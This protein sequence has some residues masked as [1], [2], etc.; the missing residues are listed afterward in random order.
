MDK[1]VKRLDDLGLKGKQF[2]E[3]L[4]ETNTIMA[5]SFPLQ[6]LL[7]E[8]YGDSDIDLYCHM[9]LYD[10][11]PPF[12]QWLYNNFKLKHHPSCINWASYNFIPGL[13]K[14][15]SYSS[16][17]ITIQIMIVNDNISPCQFV[18]TWFDLSFCEVIFDGKFLKYEDRVLNKLGSIN[19][20]YLN[21]E[22][23]TWNYIYY[24][25][26]LKYEKRGFTINNKDDYNKGREIAH[27]HNKDGYNLQPFNNKEKEISHYHDKRMLKIKNNNNVILECLTYRLLSLDNK[28]PILPYEIRQYI[29][30]LS[31]IKLNERLIHHKQLRYH[32][33]PYMNI[34]KC[35]QE[36]IMILSECKCEFLRQKIRDKIS[37]PLD[38][39]LS[40][41]Y[42]KHLDYDQPSVR[43]NLEKV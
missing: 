17:N 25:R 6:C 20:K 14:Y 31:K 9:P 42:N 23:Q 22:Y 3:K 34:V 11:Y 16:Q 35:F 33:C 15:Y 13:I 8:N 10:I 39:F 37:S 41:I 7:G 30:Y 36:N 38:N 29:I 12:G 24:D 28:T 4:Y 27:H 5:G 43:L 40:S 19:S 2:C 21:G 1:I 26:I 18:N 32:L